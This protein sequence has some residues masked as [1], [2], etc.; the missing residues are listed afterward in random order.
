MHPARLPLGAGWEGKCAAPGHEG[1]QPGT[2]ELR[3]FC[4]FGYAAGCSRLPANRPADAV[5]FSVVRDRSDQLTICFVYEL[6]HRPAAHGTLEYNLASAKWISCHADACI[7]T[8]AE[9]YL[10]SYLMRRLQPAT[11]GSSTSTN[12]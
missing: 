7:Q 10:Q 12:S 5:R 9:S 1:S 4:N 2:E 11:V 3:N 8:M 6:G